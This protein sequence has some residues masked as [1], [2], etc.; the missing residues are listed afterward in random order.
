M[1]KGGR[2]EP[3][4]PGLIGLPRGGEAGCG[5]AFGMGEEG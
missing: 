5:M 3:N 2:G 1:G 4:R